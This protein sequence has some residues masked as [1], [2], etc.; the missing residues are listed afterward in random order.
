MSA[1]PTD[2]S[3]L[4]HDAYAALRVPEFR[5]FWAGNFLA[6]LGAQMQFVAIG[7]DIYERTGQTLQLGLVG[8]VQVIPV[9]LLAL[10]AGQVI[11]RLGPPACDHRRAGGHDRLFAGAGGHRLAA[12]GLPLDLRVPVPQR[13]GACVLAARQ[14]GAVAVDRAPQPVCQRRDLEHVRLPAGDGH[15]SA[16]GWTGHRLDDFGDVGL[17]AGR[18]LVA[19][20]FVAVLFSLRP[21][22]PAASSERVGGGSLLAG[23]AFVWRTK[24]ILGAI[25]LDMFAVLLGGATALLPVYAKDILHAGAD[26]LGWLRAAPGLGALLTS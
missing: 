24:L 4:P 2:D 22:P 10:P 8:L 6:I 17:R 5:R 11:D 14:I 20:L 1:S 13:R 18:G 19:R 7:W 12:G 25:S 9:I 3:Q 15:W 26:G 23:A 21:R 16:A